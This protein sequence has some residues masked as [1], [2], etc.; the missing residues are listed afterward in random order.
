M[1]TRR[2]PDRTVVVQL[3]VVVGSSNNWI[4]SWTRSSEAP[5]AT[6]PSNS[7][8]KL[9]ARPGVP[10]IAKQME[11]AAV[12]KSSVGTNI[13]CCSNC[14]GC[15]VGSGCSGCVLER[16]ATLRL[17]GFTRSKTPSSRRIA[18]ARFLHSSTAPRTTWPPTVIRHWP[19]TVIRH[20][21]AH[22]ALQLK[23]QSISPM[24]SPS[25]RLTMR[26]GMNVC[27]LAMAAPRGLWGLSSTSS[28][29]LKQRPATMQLLYR[30]L[31]HLEPNTRL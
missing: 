31:E 17:S 14:G 1:F 21:P 8:N 4:F 5:M 19:P 23:S 10:W 18:L 3:V 13:D 7:G 6:C 15:G 26:V 12:A 24:T 27:S 30:S 9:L 25:A 2:C 29:A 16:A 11:I 22:N 20:W 28:R